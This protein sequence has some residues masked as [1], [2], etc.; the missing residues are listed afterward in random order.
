MHKYHENNDHGG[1]SVALLMKEM[2][3]QKHLDSQ[4]NKS[5]PLHYHISDM[6]DYIIQAS[7]DIEQNINPSIDKY[8]NN[9]SINW[10]KLHTLCANILEMHTQ[11][12]KYHTELEKSWRVNKDYPILEDKKNLDKIRQHINYINQEYQ[13]AEILQDICISNQAIKNSNPKKYQR[14]L[15]N[16]MHIIE[17]Y[18]NT[19][20]SKLI[21]LAIKNLQSIIKYSMK[22]AEPILQQSIHKQKTLLNKKRAATQISSQKHA[23]KSHKYTNHQRPYDRGYPHRDR[24]RKN[25][26]QFDT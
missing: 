18:S 11:A 2:E 4:N 9:K 7:N 6:M 25:K 15:D 14:N 23:K 13:Q 16:C 26:K 8:I 1:K 5:D 12:T 10:Q 22:K 24:N 19:S 21:E 17:K 20:N 3:L